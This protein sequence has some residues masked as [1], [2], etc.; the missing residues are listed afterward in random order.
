MLLLVRDNH[1]KLIL[2]TE[3]S[4][5]DSKVVFPSNMYGEEENL[6]I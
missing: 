1:M 4:E 5:Q 6:V 3:L 2:K